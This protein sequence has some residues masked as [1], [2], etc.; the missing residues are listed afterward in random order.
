M[1]SSTG[2][3]APRGEQPGQIARAHLEALTA[4]GARLPVR[5]TNDWRRNISTVIHHLGY[6]PETAGILGR[7]GN[8]E[9]FL[10]ERDRCETGRSPKEIIIGA[11]YDSADEG[12]GAD[13]NASG[14]AVM[15]ETAE[16][17]ANLQ[18]PYTIRFI[19]FG[20]EENGLDG[21]VF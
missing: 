9:D 21:S 13:D 11:H 8:F 3:S 2:G 12:T 17:V 7:D 14:V 6:K 20:S 10:A 15:L 1:A 4:I 18:T 16:L 5:R 19:A